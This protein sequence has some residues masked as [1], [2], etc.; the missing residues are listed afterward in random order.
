MYLL[1]TAGRFTEALAVAREGR[2]VARSLNT[3]T[4]LTSMLDNNTAA[5][6]ITTG[7]WAEAGRLLAELVGQSSGHVTR[8]LRLQQL[9]LSVGRGQSQRTAELAAALLKSTQDP[10]IIVQLHACLAEQALNVGDLPTAAG[11]ILDGLAAL[12]GTAPPGTAPPGAAMPA[13]E[14]RLLAVGARVSADRAVLPRPARP[15]RF[16]DQWEQ[17]AVTFA[18]RAQAI[19]ANHGHSQPE[20][21]AYCTLAAAEYAREHGTDNRAVWR[22]VAQAW[23]AAS[24]PYREAYARLR[25]A[26]A[27]VRAGRRA[28]AARAVGACEAL[29]RPLPADPLLTQARELASRAR[30][31]VEDTAATSAAVGARFDLTSRERQVLALLAWGDSNRQIARALFISDRTVAVHVSRILHKL[32]VRNRTEAATAGARLGLIPPSPPT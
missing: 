13:E 18:D 7:R 8:Y 32:G 2:Q 9:E 25:E 22:A 23:Q 28:Q 30:L 10:R 6:L 3:P 27:A 15:A 31:A 16:A 12:P 29:A 14:I 4:A 17:Q 20:I 1:G 21:A 24:Q 19:L 5:V 11:E 26:E